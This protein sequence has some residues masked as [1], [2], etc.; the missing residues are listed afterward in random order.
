M[1]LSTRPSRAAFSFFT[2]QAAAIEQVQEQLLDVHKQASPTLRIMIKHKQSKSIG[3]DEKFGWNFLHDMYNASVASHNQSFASPDL[4]PVSR[5]EWSPKLWYISAGTN[6]VEISRYKS[7]WSRLN[8]IDEKT[9]A[10]HSGLTWIQNYFLFSDW[11][12]SIGAASEIDLSSELSAAPVPPPTKFE[13]ITAHGDR[14]YSIPMIIRKDIT[15]HTIGN[16]S[17]S[18]ALWQPSITDGVTITRNV[19]AADEQADVV[20]DDAP[21]TVALSITAIKDHLR[22]MQR[23]YQRNL[24]AICPGSLFGALE[25]HIMGYASFRYDQETPL[26]DLSINASITLKSYNCTFYV[27]PMMDDLWNNTI[28]FYDPE[29]MFLT[30]NED[31]D[32]IAGSGIYDW[33]RIPGTNQS[34][35]AVFLEEQLVCPD[36]RSVGAM[37][38]YS[39]D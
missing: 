27:D 25:E 38:G 5:Q 35:T 36:R 37:H 17:S 26:R 14:M 18:E 7:P 33:E 12:E 1:A 20:T 34:A 32:P 8:M 16:V 3:P 4:D 28:W 2:E 30:F 29:S 11:S 24:Y 6:D 31:F 21:S 22:L 10:M 23:G 39:E 9:Q 15:G 19:T 13:N